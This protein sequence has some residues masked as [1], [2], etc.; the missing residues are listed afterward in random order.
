MRK[1]EL[2]ALK[3]LQRHRDH[4]RSEQMREDA[5][6]ILIYQVFVFYIILFQLFYPVMLVLNI[7]VKGHFLNI[8]NKVH[9]QTE[10]VKFSIFRADILGTEILRERNTYIEKKFTLFC[11]KQ[12]D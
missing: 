2:F 10:P 4:Y 9:F 3:T 11:L 7:L 6:Y 5:S 1:H 8:A 12:R